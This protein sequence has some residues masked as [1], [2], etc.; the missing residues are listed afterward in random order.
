MTEIRQESREKG[1]GGTH[2]RAGDST[3]DISCNY[4]SDNINN[5]YKEQSSHG[6]PLSLPLNV[7]LGAPSEI[8]TTTGANN[9]SAM[10]AETE[11][12]SLEGHAVLEPEEKETEKKAKRSHVERNRES[13]SEGTQDGSERARHYQDGTI[14]DNQNDDSK[15]PSALL[16]VAEVGA[17]SLGKESKAIEVN[18]RLAATAD[19]DASNST[20]LALSAGSL[21]QLATLPHPETDMSPPF[22]YSSPLNTHNSINTSR[23]PHPISTSPLPPPSP[24]DPSIDPTSHSCRS[25]TSRPSSPARTLVSNN[26]PSPL[27]I[28]HVDKNQYLW[29]ATTTTSSPP[30]PLSPSSS[31]N[32]AFTRFTNTTVTA[33]GAFFASTVTLSST[34][35]QDLQQDQEE[36][37][38]GRLTRSHK[39]DKGWKAWSVVLASVLIQTFAFAPTEFI[40]GVFVQEYLNM[41]PNANPSS[42]AL[43]GTIGS[44]TTY[45]FGFFSGAFSDRWGYR[46]TSVIGSL[47]MTTALCLASFSTK[48]YL[49]G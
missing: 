28:I 47:I 44:S 40:F 2:S 1:Q 29:P 31:V 33:P 37:E 45:L 7:S 21:Y 43:I 27:P 49:C 39:M 16:D 10:Q 30:P 13:R 6:Y 11:H 25:S 24:S 20:R 4:K 9:E 48:V 12:R 17:R 22:P 42:I 23:L 19:G 26:S 5:P 46:V 34:G 8:T 14:S 3:N 15:T 35:D 41:F 32:T 38:E 18:L 36:D